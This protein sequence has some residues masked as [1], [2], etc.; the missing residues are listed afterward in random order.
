M[1]RCL[2]SIVGSCVLL[3]ASS[4]SALE[5]QYV[6]LVHVQTGKVLSVADESFEAGAQIALAAESDSRAQQWQLQKD[7]DFYKVVNRR[8]LKVLDVYEAS[9]EP[10]AAI[11]Q[12]EDKDDEND[13]QRWT[14]VGEGDDRRLICLSSGL[15]LDIDGG[16]VVQRRMERSK[17]QLWR[18]K[19]VKD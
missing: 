14:W 18:V 10:G 8:S 9:P 7:G 13:N 2:S 3:T 4:V 15:V 19:V 5:I 11:I 12:W 1:I 17:S 16:N 6:K